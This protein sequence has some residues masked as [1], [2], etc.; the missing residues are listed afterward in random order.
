MDDRKTDRLTL[1]ER[2]ALRLVSIHMSSKEIARRLGISPGTVDRHLANAMQK[3]GVSSR[4]AAVRLLLE[5]AVTALP[6]ASAENPP[7]QS[8]AMATGGGGAQSPPRSPVVSGPR[9]G[10]PS[11]FGDQSLGAVLLRFVVD[12]VLVILFFAVLTAGAWAAHWIILQ[13]EA[14]H[15]DHGVALILKTVHYALVVIDGSGVVLATLL[16]TFRFLKALKEVQ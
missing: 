5:D 12:A 11:W 1:R 6:E 2:E 16:L 3:L 15:I 14:A 8:S 7:T 13:G 4:L 10:E 9:K